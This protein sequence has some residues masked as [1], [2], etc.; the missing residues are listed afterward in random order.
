MRDAR[1]TSQNNA[2]LSRGPLA[3]RPLSAHRAL[4]CQI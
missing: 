1:L 2:A 4:S 3:E